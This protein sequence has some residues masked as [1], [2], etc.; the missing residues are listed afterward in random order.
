MTVKGLVRL[1]QVFVLPPLFFWFFAAVSVFVGFQ[2]ILAPSDQLI[3][4]L[5]A[6]FLI[7]LGAVTVLSRKYIQEEFRFSVEGK[8]FKECLRECFKDYFGLY[9][10]KGKDGIA[11]AQP[12]VDTDLR[13]LA[14]EVFSAFDQENHFRG[15]IRSQTCPSADTVEKDIK[16]LQDLKH[17]SLRAK[18]RFWDGHAVASFYG[19]ETRRSYKDYMRQ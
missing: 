13:N 16:T 12:L 9:P 7:F 2:P 15:K 4:F 8:S 18:Q 1:R 11:V 5:F 3:C 10:P 6:T 14:R 17:G 19:F